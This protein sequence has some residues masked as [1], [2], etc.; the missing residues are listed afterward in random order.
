MTEPAE[1]WA[2][3]FGAES[4]W[5]C[6]CCRTVML[7]NCR[8]CPSCGYTVFDPV[9]RVAQATNENPEDTRG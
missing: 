4:A 1:V 7:K 6:Q 9:H 3:G 5:R 8:A 2:F